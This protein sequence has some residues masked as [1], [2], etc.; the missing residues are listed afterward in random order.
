[1]FRF[2]YPYA[3][4]FLAVLSIEQLHRLVVKLAKLLAQPANENCDG[5]SA[6]TQKAQ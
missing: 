6:T 3:R 2:G 1:M 4:I 5:K